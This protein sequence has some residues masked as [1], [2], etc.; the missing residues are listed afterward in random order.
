M[1]P[2]IKEERL[3]EEK[4]RMADHQR[5]RGGRLDLVVEKQKEANDDDCRRA[6]SS[7][8]CLVFGGMR[9]CLLDQYNPMLNLIGDILHQGNPDYLALNIAD[10]PRPTALVGTGQDQ[11]FLF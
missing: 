10:Y 6:G 9:L 8:P 5:Y 3:R 2:E 7:P 1:K 4:N 11:S